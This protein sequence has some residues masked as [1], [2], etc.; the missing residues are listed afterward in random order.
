VSR[1]LGPG[2]V[3]PP[4]DLG[5]ALGE[6]LPGGGEPDPPT[7]ALEQLRAGL[8]LQS[9]QV[10]GDR[11]LGVVQLLRRQRDRSMTRDGVEDAQPVDVQHSSILSMIPDENWHLTYEM[12]DRKL[13]P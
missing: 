7:D 3:D 11:R 6:Q 2:G 4:Y 1:E 5:G 13:S 8:D 12:P 10:V 9:G